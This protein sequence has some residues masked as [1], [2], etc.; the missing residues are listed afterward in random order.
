ML[1]TTFP[2]SQV[3]CQAIFQYHALKRH[4]LFICEADNSSARHSGASSYPRPGWRTQQ[5]FTNLTHTASNSRVSAFCLQCS[6][7][8]KQSKTQLSQATTTHL[9]CQRGKRACFDSR[10]GPGPLHAAFCLC[11]ARM[12]LRHSY[13]SSS[14][15]TTVGAETNLRPITIHESAEVKVGFIQCTTSYRCY[16]HDCSLA[17]YYSTWIKR[18]HWHLGQSGCSF[19]TLGPWR[20]QLN[21][22]PTVTREMAMPNKA[23]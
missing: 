10:R 17:H 1:S 13:S 21:H 15:D 22:L 18:T 23:Q 2:H 20:Q 8:N 3:E 11:V 19:V 9:L 7:I 16:C 6:S 5:N 14:S 12:S 4:C